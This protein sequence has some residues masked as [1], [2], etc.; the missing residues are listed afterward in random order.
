MLTTVGGLVGLT[1]VVLSACEGLET[2]VVGL[3]AAGFSVSAVVSAG[4]A[5]VVALVSSAG[6]VSSASVSWAWVSSGCSSALVEVGWVS[7]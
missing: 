2:M 4:A 6:W 3:G 1:T 5:A 7:A